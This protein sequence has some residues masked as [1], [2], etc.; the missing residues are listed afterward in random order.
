MAR[1]TTRRIGCG[2][3]L[4]TLSKKIFQRARAEEIRLGD[5]P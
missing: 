5:F 2:A 1:M 3:G 4:K